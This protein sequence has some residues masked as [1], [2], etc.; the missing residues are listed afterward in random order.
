MEAEF[1]FRQ[2]VVA[3]GSYSCSVSS[4]FWLSLRVE[5]AFRLFFFGLF[6]GCWQYGTSLILI[7]A[8]RFSEAPDDDKP[9]LG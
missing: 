8:L 6:V 1:Q 2:T 9:S 4:Y 5:V 7:Q 3:L